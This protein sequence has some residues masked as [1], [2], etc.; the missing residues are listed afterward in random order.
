MI[1]RKFGIRRS[2][3]DAGVVSYFSTL[4]REKMPWARNTVG[5]VVVDPVD[6]YG[7]AR[8]GGGHTQTHTHT[9]AV[10]EG[11]GGVS[12]LVQQL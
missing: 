11:G 1:K 3:H 9:Q 8:G 7:L 12:Y 6:L 5:V 10:M 2:D 4:M